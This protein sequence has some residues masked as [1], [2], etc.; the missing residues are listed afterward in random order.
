MRPEQASSWAPARTAPWRGGSHP[1]CSCHKRQLKF[2]FKFCLFLSKSQ[3]MNSH[4]RGRSFTPLEQPM[5]QSDAPAFSQAEGKAG[6]YPELGNSLNFFPYLDLVSTGLASFYGR[7]PCIKAS[8][9]P[10][11]RSS[12]GVLLGSYYTG[13]SSH[14]LSLRL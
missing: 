10:K 3:S 12:P 9:L 6:I 11:T 1:I 2:T 14:P 13:Y 4:G 5:V 8:R 7:V